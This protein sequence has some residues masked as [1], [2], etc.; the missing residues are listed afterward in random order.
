[1]SSDYARF[2]QNRKNLL[3]HILAVP[4]FVVCLVTSVWLLVSGQYLSALLW[5]LGTVLSLALQGVGHKLEPVPPEPFHGP[6]NF[7][8]RIL[9]EQ[10]YRFWVFVLSR[11]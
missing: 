7:L 4:L 8:Q 3:I 10:F 9:L 2:H 6:L 1:V 11:E 5:F